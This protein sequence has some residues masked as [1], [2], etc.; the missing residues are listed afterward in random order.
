ML[1]YRMKTQ[2]IQISAV[3]TLVLVLAIMAAVLMPSQ[4]MAQPDWPEDTEWR[5][6]DT[7]ADD[8]GG[9][10][11]R[12][13]TEA[14]WSCDGVYLYLRLRTVAPPYFTSP[15]R[16]KWFIDVGSGLNLYKSG[17]SI[18]G[19]DYLLF[20]EDSNNDGNG[21]IYLLP[22]IGGDDRFSSY[23]PWNKSNVAPINNPSI[24]SYRITSNYID[25]W[26]PFSAIGKT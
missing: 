10:N 24:A 8:S 15:T 26:I 21:E 3:L 11:Y 12:D 16:Y 22:V 1:S 13:V 7:D 14:Y 4:A 20:V 2:F 23:E 25:M 9:A 17:G 5:L 6:I 19:T 18:L